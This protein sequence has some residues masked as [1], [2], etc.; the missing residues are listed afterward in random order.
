M[1]SQRD[2]ALFRKIAGE[3]VV[4]LDSLSLRFSGSDPALSKYYTRLMQRIAEHY[5]V[6]MPKHEVPV[7]KRCHSRMVPGISAEVRLSSSNRYVVYTCSSC[8]YEK[9]LHY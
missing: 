6:D 2:K 3:R 5:K 9:H 8:G 4:I 1:K 7:C